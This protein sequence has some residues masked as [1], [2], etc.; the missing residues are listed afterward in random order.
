L[1]ENYFLHLFKDYIYDFSHK[2]RLILNFTSK[3]SSVFYS[4]LQMSILPSS[5]TAVPFAQG[6]DV[7]RLRMAVDMFSQE[8]KDYAQE[9]E[10]H[11]AIVEALSAAKQAEPGNKPKIED[12]RRKGATARG[13]PTP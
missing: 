8:I 10:D 5:S 9:Y 12:P 4:S 3:N 6:Q 11:R 2:G 1:I 7:S 13:S